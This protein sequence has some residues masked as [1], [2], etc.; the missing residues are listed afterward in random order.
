[1]RSFFSLPRAVRCYCTLRSKILLIN[2]RVAG[3]VGRIFNCNLSRR[4]SHLPS[5]EN[6]VRLTGERKWR[7]LN[8]KSLTSYIPTLILEQVYILMA[9]GRLFVASDSDPALRGDIK[10]GYNADTFPLQ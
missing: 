5:F 2:W 4:D 1:M 10:K 3:D 7:T 6:V 8:V 9:S